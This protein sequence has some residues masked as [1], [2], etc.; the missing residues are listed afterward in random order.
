MNSAVIYVRSST[1]NRADIDKQIENCTKFA[2]E[3]I[4]IVTET[5]VDTN[6]FTLERERLIQE[7]KFQKVRNV[8]VYSMDRLTRN[9]EELEILMKM[10]EDNT[11]NIFLCKGEEASS[12]SSF[13]LGILEAMANFETQIREERE[14][15]DSAIEEFLPA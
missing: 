12:L 7:C 4:M 13:Q 5:Y 10:F 1:N 8:I 2:E 9:L 15:I 11:V 6:K 3:N 14:L